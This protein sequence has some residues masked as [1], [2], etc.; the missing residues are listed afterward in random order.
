VPEAVRAATGAAGAVV[1]RALRPGDE[2]EEIVEEV[3]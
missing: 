1:L 3:R 2:I